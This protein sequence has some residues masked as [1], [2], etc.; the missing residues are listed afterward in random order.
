MRPKYKTLPHHFFFVTKPAEE[1][2]K[3]TG[4]RWFIEGDIR[5]CFDEIDH[6]ILVNIIQE[7]IQDERFIKLL[8]S[9]LKAGYLEDWRYHCT[10]SGVPQGGIISPLLSNI[11]LNRLDTYVREELAPQYT[12]GKERSKN[13]EY[14][15]IVHRI[16][17]ARKRGQK[18]LVRELKKQQRQL[19]SRTPHDP[20]FRRL[21]YARYADDFILGFSGPKSEAQQIKCAL[22]TYLQT[23]GLTLS[24]EKTKISHAKTESA[25]F[26]GYEITTALNN[27]K[28]SMNK[29]YKQRSVNAKIQLRVPRDIVQKWVS[30]FSQNGKPT[31]QNRD[32]NL[33]DFEIVTL[34]GSQLRGLINYYKLAVNLSTRL[35]R[36]RWTVMEATRKTL[37]RKH[38]MKSAR[39]AY[40]RY[41]HDGENGELK[42]IRIA[43]ERD[44]KTPLIAKCGETNLKRMPTWKINDQMPNG[45][46]AGSRNELTR[47]LLAEECELCGAPGPLEGHH[48]RK[49]SD[50]KK[51]WRGRKK[52]PLWVEAMIAR[53]RKSI[54]VCHQCHLDI[55]CGRYDGPKVG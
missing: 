8:K 35:H 50:L 41:Y 7:D 54:F 11:F 19:P 25:R 45:Y 44:D 40:R 55:T 18:T 20:N 48:I 2:T 14:M 1:P 4:A 36:V 28:L 53:N 22:R 21:Y 42:H 47:R 34:I 17:R 15:T 10:Y 3:W 29:G 6:K 30:R 37:M 31:H 13:P 23:M 46:T 33:S 24:E 12:K 27:A 51:R 9:M 39:Q 52:K 26:L 16:Y 32:A 38:K 49:L 43:I 5:G